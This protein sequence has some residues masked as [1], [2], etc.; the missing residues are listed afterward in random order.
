MI[1][2]RFRWFVAVLIACVVLLAGCGGSGGSDSKNDPAPAPAPS[3]AAGP[4]AAEQQ[5]LDAVNAQRSA[6]GRSALTWNNRLGQAAQDHT[7]DMFDHS[8]MSHTGSDGSTASQRV[9][10]AGYVWQATGENVAAGQTSV[11]QVM[12]DWMNSSGHRAN[13]LSVNYTEFGCARVGNYWTQVFGKPMSSG[14]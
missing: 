12:T 4:T 2:N 7:Q 6:N 3:I 1:P 9:T 14:G 10:A 11:T 13:I 5:L 8:T